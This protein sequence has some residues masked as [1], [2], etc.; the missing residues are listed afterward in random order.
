[1]PLLICLTCSKSMGSR[2]SFMTNQ[3]SK[4]AMIDSIQQEIDEIF[5][6]LAYA[7]VYRDWQDGSMPRAK[8]KGYN[9]GCIL[10]NVQNEPV[11]WGLNS[12]GITNNATQHGEVRA[13]I[14]YLE[15]TGLFDLKDYTIY[16][17]LEPCAM[18]GGMMVMTSIKRTVYGQ[19]DVEYSHALERLSIDSRAVGGYP[20]FPRNVVS[21]PSPSPFREKLNESYGEFLKKDPE[22]ILAKFL[23]SKQAKNVFAQANEAFIK[24]QVKETSNIGVYER[25]IAFY[26]ANHFQRNH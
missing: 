26:K 18:C 11:Y 14:N 3:K 17:T 16:T 24:Y 19:N 2:Q 21:D 8:R 5:T 7:I 13:M 22:K 23:V 20:P 15:S 6:L 25:A 1:M 4:H 9:I 12:V 10:V